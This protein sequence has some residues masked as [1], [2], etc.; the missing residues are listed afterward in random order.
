MTYQ[1]IYYC[2][3]LPAWD[4]KES[5]LSLKEAENKL[6]TWKNRKKGD[7]TKMDCCEYFIQPMERE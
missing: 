2:P 1:I 4:I 6:I 7:K 5:N 3:V